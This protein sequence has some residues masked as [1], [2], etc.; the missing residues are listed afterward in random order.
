MTEKRRKH[1]KL[2]ACHPGLST[3]C[4]YFFEQGCAACGVQMGDDF[5]EEQDRRKSFSHMGKLSRLCKHDGDQE[6]FLLARGAVA[7]L[8]TLEGMAR[9]NIG[10]M[11]PESGSPA[12]ASRTRQRSSISR[13]TFALSSV[14]SANSRSA[15]PSKL[16]CADG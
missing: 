7:R 10:D 15:S 9:Q 5:V 13:K 14:L 16:S 8:H 6:C 4:E 11:R 1:R 2:S 3:Q 12:S